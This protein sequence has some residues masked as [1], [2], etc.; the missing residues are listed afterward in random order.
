MKNVKISSLAM[1]CAVA[2]M[3]VNLLGMGVAY[4]QPFAWK[5]EKGRMMYGD[6][7]PSQ[8]KELRDLSR[9]VESDEPL[10]ELTIRRIN[11][12]TADSK[13]RLMP[14]VTSSAAPSISGNSGVSAAIASAAKSQIAPIPA[15]PNVVKP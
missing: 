11:T 6:N 4:A 15:M 13:K 9:P 3:S 12:P 7:P 14:S 8:A 5:D 10:P 1:I 2:V